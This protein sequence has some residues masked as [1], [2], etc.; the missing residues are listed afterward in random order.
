MSAGGMDVSLCKGRYRVS[1][2]QTG[3]EIADAQRLR[4]RCFATSSA[5]DSDRYDSAATHVTIHDSASGEMVCCFRLT[6]VRG[7]QIDECYS[8]QF[9]DLQKLATFSGLMME[10][11][12]FCIH[13]EWHDPDILRLA[14]AAMTAVVDEKDVRLLFG[15]SSYEGIDAGPYA[16]S[17]ARLLEKYAAPQD[18]APVKKSPETVDF[19]SIKMTELT[20]IQ[21]ATPPLLRTYLIMGGWV[22]DH[23]VVDRALGTLHVFTGLEI[24]AIPETRKRLLR[25]LI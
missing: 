25:A 1:T 11:G 6:L 7:S 22:S 12:R 21:R 23:A 24:A 2:A 20:Q 17:F 10:L 3:T 9:Y 4:A 14:W 15:C 16:A 19:A 18:L 5:Q 8:A 13:P